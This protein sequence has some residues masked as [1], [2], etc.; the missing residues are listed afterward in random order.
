MRNI[1]ARKAGI[2]VIPVERGK[3][4]QHGV[5]E[6]VRRLLWLPDQPPAVTFEVALEGFEQRQE[7]VGVG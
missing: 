1:Q 3:G 7:A 5:L 2:L 6:G 4:A